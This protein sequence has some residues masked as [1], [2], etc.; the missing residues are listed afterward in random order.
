MWEQSAYK[1]N[2][3]CVGSVSVNMLNPTFIGICMI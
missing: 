1:A 2:P 3:L